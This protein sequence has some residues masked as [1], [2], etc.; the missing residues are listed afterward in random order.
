MLLRSFSHRSRLRCRRCCWVIGRASQRWRWATPPFV[1]TIAV[2]RATLA[3][4]TAVV[5]VIV[6]A[7]TMLV[8]TIVVFFFFFFVM[9]IVITTTDAVTTTATIVVCRHRGGSGGD[10]CVSLVH[11]RRGRRCGV[12]SQRWLARAHHAVRIVFDIVAHRV[13]QFVGRDAV[14][15]VVA[16]AQHA[17]LDVAH[18]T[19]QVDHHG[20]QHRR[21][22]GH[23]QH[24]RR[25]RSYHR[26]GCWCRRR[27][28]VVAVK[29]VATPLLLL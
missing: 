6:G 2:H 12:P 23:H 24:R 3:L 20:A 9:M 8:R 27:S 7:T 11:R 10:C 14:I 16:D 17:A 5:I 25:R 19:Y 21:H 18:A 1:L 13:V 22:A 4:V 28:V 29:R 26:R 15:G